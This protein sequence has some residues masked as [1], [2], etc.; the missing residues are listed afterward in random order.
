MGTR[1]SREDLQRYSNSSS[2]AMPR[3]ERT[4]E[5][6]FERA[7]RTVVAVARSADESVAKM[8]R[9]RVRGVLSVVLPFRGTVSDDGVEHGSPESTLGWKNGS[10]QF[11][12]RDTR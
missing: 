1:V 5:N 11:T 9:V 6:I 10:W 8:M 12:R 7:Q 4:W 2:K 3:K